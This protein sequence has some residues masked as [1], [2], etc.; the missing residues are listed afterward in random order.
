MMSEFNGEQIPPVEKTFRI[1]LPVERAFLLF[2]E[3]MHTWWP[4]ESHS[5]GG[6]QT[7]TCVF[8]PRVGGR[9][10]EIQK[11]GTEVEWGHVQAWEPPNRVIFVWHPG[12]DEITA[13][14]VE[15]WFEVMPG[16]A[17]VHLTH[18]GWERLG[19]KAHEMR[20]DYDT[21]W[22]TVLAR[23]SERA[24]FLGSSQQPLR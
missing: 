14:E 19:A 6:D 1:S 21:G 7:E 23:Y 11:D 22:D 16:G 5:V 20:E 10:Y 15:V 9:I 8:E 18:R 12:R 2:T 24:A 13:Q 3:E 4:L 17:I